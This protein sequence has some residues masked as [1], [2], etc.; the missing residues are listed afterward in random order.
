MN[1]IR[2][3][4]GVWQRIQWSMLYYFALNHFLNF[5]R[6]I[7]HLHAQFFY[8]FYF[9]LF[10]ATHVFD[11]LSHYVTSRHYLVSY[12]QQ[13]LI[14]FD[15]HIMN[16]SF[17]TFYHYKWVTISVTA[18]S[19]WPD[20]FISWIRWWCKLWYPQT[21]SI[22][23]RTLFWVSNNRLRWIQYSFFF[24]LLALGILDAAQPVTWCFKYS[25]SQG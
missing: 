25:R 17:K 24:R 16:S 1:F 11:F 19:R 22:I 14:S 9:C 3:R 23:Y 12:Q 21:F 13:I 4:G 15:V 5:H 7:S 18:S 6:K 10:L 20:W 2:F 8:F